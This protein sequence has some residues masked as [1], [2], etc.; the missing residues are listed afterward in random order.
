M[1]MY[2]MFKYLDSGPGYS[3]FAAIQYTY[4][5]DMLVLHVL[6]PIMGLQ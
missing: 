5:G 2:I 3:H 6:F 1:S 4:F